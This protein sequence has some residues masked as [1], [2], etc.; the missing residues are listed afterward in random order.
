MSEKN[1]LPH[2]PWA[3]SVAF[4]AAPVETV[5]LGLAMLFSRVG[6]AAALLMLQRVVDTVAAGGTSAE[7]IPPLGMLA[8]AVVLS[9]LGTAAMRFIDG[10]L[11][12]KLTPTVGEMVVERT[13]TLSLAEYDDPNT[14]D[15]IQRASDGNVARIFRLSFISI[16]VIALALGA[17]SALALLGAVSPIIAVIAM[18]VALP[19]TWAGVRQGARWYDLNKRQSPGRRFTAYLGNMLS[20]REAATELRAYQLVD[21]F[22]AKWRHSF[23][24]RRED[25]LV[26][27]WAGVREGWMA[28][29]VGALLM[30]TALAIL[31]HL[32]GSGAVG[33]GQIVALVGAARLLQANMANL[34]QETG[35]LWE[36][37]LPVRELRQ[38]LA[39]PGVTRPDS[40]GVSFPR[41]TKG[42]RFEN[43]SFAY[44]GAE[45]PVLSGVNLEIQPGETVALVGHNGA[46]KST[47]IKLLLGLYQPTGGRILFDGV[48]LQSIAPKSLREN[49][50]CVFQ[51]F[52]RYDFTV[53]ENIA[54]GKLGAPLD[55]VVAATRAAGLEDVVERLERRYDTQLG[56]SFIGGKDLSGGQW[57]RVAIARA[58]IRGAQVLVL[59]EPTAALDPRAELEVFGKFVELVKDR[60]AILISHRLGSCKMAD[61][62][63]VLEG[64]TVVEHGPHAELMAAGGRYAE[65]FH[66]QAQ[67]YVDEAPSTEKEV[68]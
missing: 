58:F 31:A 44:P 13:L 15:L 65:L 1:P 53:G 66:M 68:G 39:L 20:S 27:R 22:L 37:G 29:I 55:E 49:L 60:T 51:D 46:G 34:A 30:G 63:I 52:V 21:F 16:N 48:D 56:K 17:A 10:R 42:I 54:V 36:Q 28:K 50:S 14:H 47:L 12:E 45:R 2:V 18:A 19:I 25:H 3:I 9:E 38:F 7:L 41:L 64:G 11:W 23:Q 57:Q 32:A 26:V 61:R 33:A 35:V 59:D 8:G 43:V 24:Q 62:I 4:R 5:S 40:E 67:W 6:P